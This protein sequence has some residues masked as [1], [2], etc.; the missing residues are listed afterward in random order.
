MPIG[1]VTYSI[2]Q[3]VNP[4]LG[5]LG[6]RHVRISEPLLGQPMSLTRD[7]QTINAGAAIETILVSSDGFS[8]I[9]SHDSFYGSLGNS[10]QESSHSRFEY[11]NRDFSI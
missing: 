11:P 7:Q 3:E 4:S 6:T 2:P 9:Y 8:S 10:T 5:G 1:P